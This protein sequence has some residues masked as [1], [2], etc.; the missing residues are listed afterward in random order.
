[1]SIQ[2]LASIYSGLLLSL[3]CQKPSVLS[4]SKPI[5]KW[6]IQANVKLPGRSNVIGLSFMLPMSDNLKARFFQLFIM[7]D[8]KWLALSSRYLG[9]FFKILVRCRKL[10]PCRF[11]NLL[12]RPE[13]AL[14]VVDSGVLNLKSTF[15]FVKPPDLSTWKTFLGLLV[16]WIF[17]VLDT[18]QY[19][20]S[21]NLEWSAC[22]IEGFFYEQKLFQKIT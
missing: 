1:M 2:C 22:Q 16:L 15:S 11:M 6:L 7:K 10:E 8:W 21:H 13:D 9:S 12:H 19:L 4:T 14:N 5:S 18:Y 20:W 3:H 17:P